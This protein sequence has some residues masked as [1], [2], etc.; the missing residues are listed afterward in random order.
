MRYVDEIVKIEKEYSDKIWKNYYNYRDKINELQDSKVKEE[1][2]LIDERTEKV[3]KILNE[4]VMF[5]K[6]EMLHFECHGSGYYGRFDKIE[7]N[8]IYMDV[9]TKG[10]IDK[11]FKFAKHIRSFLMFDRLDYK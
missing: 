6:G 7:D 10:G 9:C 4:N 3:N 2:R 8:I 11:G 5:E 1:N